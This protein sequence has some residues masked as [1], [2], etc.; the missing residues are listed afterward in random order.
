MIYG[1]LFYTPVCMRCAPEGGRLICRDVV[2]G[3][4]GADNCRTI[5]NGATPISCSAWGIACSRITVI[6]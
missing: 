5:F 3:Q 4:T 6:G 2:D 1:Q